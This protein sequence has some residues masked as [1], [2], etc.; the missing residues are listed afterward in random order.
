MELLQ[1][2]DEALAK[3]LSKKEFF[4]LVELELKWAGKIATAQNFS[5]DGSHNSVTTSFDVINMFHEILS[6]VKEY[7]GELQRN[8]DA[9]EQSNVYH[10][11]AVQLILRSQKLELDQMFLEQSL[12]SQKCI[13]EIKNDIEVLKDSKLDSQNDSKYLIIDALKHSQQI[14][15]DSL[16]KLDDEL[17]EARNSQH[18]IFQKD[19]AYLQKKLR[20][21]A[22]SLEDNFILL[23]KSVTALKDSIKHMEKELH[24]IKT[25]FHS[26]NS[27]SLSH[28]EGGADGQE[29]SREFFNAQET[30]QP[31]PLASFSSSLDTLFEATYSVPYHYLQC[32]KLNIPLLDWLRE[33]PLVKNKPSL[34]FVVFFVASYVFVYLTLLSS[35][36]KKR[37]LK[38]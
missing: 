27:N 25:D 21:L 4:N 24:S 22:G 26:L 1:K 2:M 3:G 31:K 30:E 6:Q 10:Q 23:N 35:R 16:K 12:N 17:N 34:L 7:S 15:L 29:L 19:N 5:E 18:N 8:R 13:E 14:I 28:S 32:P 38:W 20:E 37:W 33:L 11:Q 9:L 36:P